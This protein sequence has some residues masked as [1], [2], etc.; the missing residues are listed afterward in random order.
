[1]QAVL[2]A[3]YA[4]MTPKTLD[5]KNAIVGNPRTRPGSYGGRPRA[6]FRD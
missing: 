6:W 4:E 5:M 1:M 3:H 2:G